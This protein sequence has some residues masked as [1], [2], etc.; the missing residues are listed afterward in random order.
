MKFL[1]AIKLDKWWKLVLYIGIGAVVASLYFQIS[2]I[3]NKHLFGLGI[4]MFLIG[5]SLWIAE[6]HFSAIKPPNVYTGPT[7]LI[8]WTEIRHNPVTIILFLLGLIFIGLFGFLI[9]KNLI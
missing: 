8:S 4:G 9:L 1:D 5:L 6:Q 2:F 7:A 3:E